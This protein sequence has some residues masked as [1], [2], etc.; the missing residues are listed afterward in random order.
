MKS[1]NPCFNGRGVKTTK[2]IGYIQ[3]ITE[4]QSLF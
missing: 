4:F 1:F 2:H 3:D